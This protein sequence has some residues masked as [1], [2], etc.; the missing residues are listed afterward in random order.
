MALVLVGVLMFSQIKSIDFSDL[1]TVTSAFV[2]MIMMVL[3]YSI[4]MGIAFGFIVYVLTMMVQ[5]RFK[6]VDPVMYGLAIAFI[7]YFI[8]E[9]VA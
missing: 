3:T 2:V 5:K 6:E 8:V 7:I 1:P 9:T 4:G